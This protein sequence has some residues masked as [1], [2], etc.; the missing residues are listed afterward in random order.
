M[1]SAAGK[2]KDVPKIRRNKQLE[3]LSGYAGIFM[4]ILIIFILGGGVYDII[5]HPASTMVTSS[6][7]YTS[8]SPYSG[9]QTIN[10]SIVS[11]FLYASGF[12]GLYLVYRS[13][14]VLYDKSKANL[15]LML[16]LG[17]AVV[18]FAG[19][20]ILMILKRSA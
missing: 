4:V 11:M 19:S 15:N 7:A 2:P 9:E 10:E 16:G 17:L 18:G 12:A 3:A 1:A 6:G 8:I 5:K 14:Q 13:T 20:Y